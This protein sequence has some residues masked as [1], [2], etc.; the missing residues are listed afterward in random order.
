M[1]VQGGQEAIY[2]L[3]AKEVWWVATSYQAPARANFIGKNQI[4]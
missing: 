1:V 4:A 3:E 2:G